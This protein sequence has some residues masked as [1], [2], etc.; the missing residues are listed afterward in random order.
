MIALLVVGTLAAAS[1]AAAQ[2]TLTVYECKDGQQFAL[3][4][5][6][7]DRRAHLQLNG[8]PLSLRRW[9]SLAG[10]ARFSGSGVTLVVSKTG[11]TLKDRKQPLTACNRVE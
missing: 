6:A 7:N 10:G 1:P 8:R 11:A 4:L 3:G 2:S 9:S 5:Y